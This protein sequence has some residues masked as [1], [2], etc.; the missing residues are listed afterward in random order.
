MLTC[1]EKE[2]QHCRCVKIIGEVISAF[3]DLREHG[4]RTALRDGHDG[5]D[6]HSDQTGLACEFLASFKK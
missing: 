2:N 4:K 6:R 5:C 1:F 3:T